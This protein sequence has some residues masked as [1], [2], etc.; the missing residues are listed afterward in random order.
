M[1]LNV[2]K[3]TERKTNYKSKKQKVVSCRKEVS[4]IASLIKERPNSNK[5][6][7]KKAPK[8]Y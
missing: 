8:K 3:V 1:T 7:Q 5:Y 6:V 4:H 2:T